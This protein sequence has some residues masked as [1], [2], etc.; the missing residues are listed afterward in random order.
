MDD[1]QKVFISGF[2]PSELKLDY[3]EWVDLV[4][5][6]ELASDLK[7][8]L[9]CWKAWDLACSPMDDDERRIVRY[10]HYLGWF[11]A[12]KEF[13]HK[14]SDCGGLAGDCDCIPYNES[15]LYDGE[16]VDDLT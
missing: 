5:N 13:C 7:K 8:W 6:R 12:E 15:D 4:S 3:T 2:R 11:D 16:V 10:G 14:C 9:Y 1:S